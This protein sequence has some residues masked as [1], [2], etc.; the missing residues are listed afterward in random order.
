M[1]GELAL[2]VSRQVVDDASEVEDI[3]A[4]GCEG[5]NEYDGRLGVRISAI[6]VILITASLGQWDTRI[7]I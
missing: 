5:G 3:P 6:F 2:L 4:A 1:I 7:T